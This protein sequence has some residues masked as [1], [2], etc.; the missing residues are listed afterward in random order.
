[1]KS[2][3]LITLLFST[4][5][6]VS[7]GSDNEVTSQVDIPSTFSVDIP[8]SI[9]SNSGGLSGRIAGDDDGVIEG[10]EIYESLRGFI[11][12]GEGSAEIIEITLQVAAALEAQNVRSY[13]FESADDKR[14]K[15]IDLSESVTRGGTS[16]D[17]EM[18]MV[19]TENEDMAIQLLWNTGPVDGVGI[20]KPY[21]VD[22]I[23]NI[24]SLDALI[25]IDYSEDDANYDAT[26][27]VSI[28]GLETP[29]N[30]DI[31]NLKMF[32]GKKGDV[33]DVMG[34]SNHPNIVIIDENYT[35]GRNYAFVAR[36]DESTDL[37]VAKLALPP[38]ST[39]TADVLVDF[40]VFAVLEAEIQAAGITD[41][42]IIDAVLVEALSPAYFNND[43]FI[44]SGA[45]NKPASF[46]ASFVD[47][48][49]MNPFAPN[50]VKNLALDFI[51]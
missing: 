20:I 17:F 48:S 18:T 11:M 37:G 32:V 16:Y 43:G 4:S 19:D 42:D 21:H 5:L 15:R 12:I 10:N 26:M 9:S 3:K 27:T 49:G 41:Q 38:S 8:N 33:V 25:R 2:I 36:G 24:E 14:E 50:T 13:T 30:G 44:T 51:K 31:D 1:M 6:L 29:E 34:N 28:V 47:L 46:D 35:G 39:A 40:S 45:D 22:R 23:E 7:C